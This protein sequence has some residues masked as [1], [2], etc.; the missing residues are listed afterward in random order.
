[1]PVPSLFVAGQARS[2]ALSH[3]QDGVLDL[4]KFVADLRALN[5]FIVER[6]K[7]L[8]RFVLAPRQDQP[9]RALGEEDQDD[10]CNECKA[11]LNRYGDAPHCRSGG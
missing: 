10:K 11:D 9:T 7:H 3:N 5:I 8:E 2:A 6:A 4:Q 1:M